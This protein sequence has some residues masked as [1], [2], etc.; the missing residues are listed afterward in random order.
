LVD[1]RGLGL[2][3]GI[4]LDDAE[5]TRRVALECFAGGLILNWTLHRERVIRLAPPLAICEADLDRGLEIL[6]AAIS[7]VCG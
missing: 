5:F 3:I 7:E 6:A 1:V 2:L 4:E